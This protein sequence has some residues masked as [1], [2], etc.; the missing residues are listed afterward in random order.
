MKSLNLMHMGLQAQ[1]MSI[2]SGELLTQLSD[3]Q[4][5]AIKADGKDIVHRPD[6]LYLPQETLAENTAD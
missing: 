4:A 2:Q 6:E 1:L 5:A 3:E